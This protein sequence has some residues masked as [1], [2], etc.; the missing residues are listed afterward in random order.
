MLINPVKM[1]NIVAL[2]AICVASFAVVFLELSTTLMNNIRS[3]LYLRA[4]V[5]YLST[6]K[7]I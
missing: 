7:I 5:R 6:L 3:T 1:A 2:V 4:S